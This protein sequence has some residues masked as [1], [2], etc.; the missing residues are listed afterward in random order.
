MSDTQSAVM[1]PPSAL[2]KVFSLTVLR[3]LSQAAMIGILGQW[4]FYG[5]FRCPFLVPYVSCQN[6]PVITCHGRLFTM[7]WGFWLALP[8]S[9]LLFGR[10]FCGWACPGGFVSQLLGKI[11]PFELRAKNL[12][13]RYAAIGQYIGLLA[14]I[15]VYFYYDQMR[16]NVPIRAGGFWESVGL[17][18]EHS[19]MLWLVRSFIVTGLLAMG[20]LIA[21]MW[22]RFACPTSGMLEAVKRISLFKFYKTSECNDCDRCV[23]VCEMG[24]R[25]DET[26]CT[27]CGDC[28]GVCPADAIRFGRKRA[29]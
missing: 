18:F 22:C 4:S 21:N 28:Q 3:R 19:G 16:A 29:S 1:N 20:L 14:C 9:V 25:P 11:A 13:S 7:F 26:N 10:A 23:K 2:K 24:T 5:I 12:F 8:I 6:C 27:N 15:A 17:T